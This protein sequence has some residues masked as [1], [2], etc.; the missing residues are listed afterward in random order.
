MSWYVAAQSSSLTSPLFQPSMLLCTASKCESAN[1]QS[2]TGIGF[3]RLQSGNGPEPFLDSEFN[4]RSPQFSPD[5]NGLA[6]YSDESGR[7]E[8]YVRSFPNPDERRLPVSTEGSELGFVWSRD[9]RE[10][11]YLNGDRI[12]AV[13]DGEL[14]TLAGVE[15]IP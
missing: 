4:E 6:Y 11:F 8:S 9:G 14:V 2:N 10:L 12:M 1:P 5:G 15:A 3:V 13:E 7:G